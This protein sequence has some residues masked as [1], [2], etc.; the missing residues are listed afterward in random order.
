MCYDECGT[1]IY[2]SNN[3]F[4][5][6][7]RESDSYTQGFHALL[8]SHSGECR[9]LIVRLF[10]TNRNHEMSQ[11]FQINNPQTHTRTRKAISGL[12]Y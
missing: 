6:Y 11:R 7:F 3:N 9:R 8:H 2:F 1:N 4:A 5:C 12:S 10:S